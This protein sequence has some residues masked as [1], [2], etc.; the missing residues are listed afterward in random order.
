MKKKGKRVIFSSLINKEARVLIAD[1]GVLI[2]LR[3]TGCFSNIVRALPIPLAITEC[4]FSE[5][6]QG[7]RSDR[8]D[9]EQ[10]GAYLAQGLLTRI[11][12]GDIGNR[13]YESLV[14]GPAIH[15][16][17]DGEASTIACAA[18]ISGV[19][20]TDD[21]KVRGICSSRFP[22]VKMVSTVDL[23]THESVKHALGSTCQTDAIFFALQRVRMR[24]LPAQVA[25]VRA[26]IGNDRA[27]L[28]KSL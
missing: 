21:R 25:I 15:T 28:C 12:L 4:T 20:V 27:S 18:E 3:A 19:A 10:F 7:I 13:L 5:M 8:D 16:L 1:P 14:E 6:A 23:L 9:N 22:A 24:V 2:N 11:Q 26:L 17:N